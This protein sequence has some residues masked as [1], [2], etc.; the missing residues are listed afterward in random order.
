ML[1]ALVYEALGGERG[2]GLRGRCSD[3]SL[4]AA[5][6]SRD[7]RAVERILESGASPNLKDASGN[8]PLY[9]AILE[10]SIFLATPDQHA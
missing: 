10:S 2:D 3:H 1:S 6:F 4:H 5:E 8:T 7:I 9:R